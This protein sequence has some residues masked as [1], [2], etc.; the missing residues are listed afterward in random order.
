MKTFK[1]FTNDIVL[2]LTNTAILIYIYL[3]YLQY[4][5][6]NLLLEIFIFGIG[7]Y[8]LSVGITLIIVML[9][10]LTTYSLFN[11]I[12]N[13]SIFKKLEV[14]VFIFDND[15]KNINSI[16]DFRLIVKDYLKLQLH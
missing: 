13:Y 9:L 3:N 6:M 11:Q 14:L 12:K 5:E 15:Y 7:Y 4:Y 10:Y 16:Y 8:L 2:F 1:F